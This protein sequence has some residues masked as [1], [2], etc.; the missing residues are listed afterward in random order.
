MTA[1]RTLLRSSALLAAATAAVLAAGCGDSSSDDNATAAEGATPAAEQISTPAAPDTGKIGVFPVPGTPTASPQTQ[2]SIRGVSAKD[3]GELTVTGA[4][5]G[6][7][8]GTVKAHSD[9][10]GASFLPDEPFSKTGE[11]VTVKSALAIAGVKGGEY[12][13]TVVGRPK[14]GLQSD[15]TAL[16]PKLLKALTGQSGKVVQGDATFKSRR[17]LRPPAIQILKKPAKTAPGEIFLSPKIVFGAKRPKVQNGPMILDDAGNPIW[18]AATG[19]SS[20][21]GNANR[22][23]DFRVQTYKGEPHLTWW[24]GRQVLG[25]GEGSVQIVDKN[26]KKVKTVEGGNGYKLDFHEARLTDQGTLLGL[27]YNPVD[28]DLTSVGGPKKGRVVDA[29][30]QEIDIETGLVLFEWHSIG[31]IPLEESYEDTIPKNGKSLFDYVHANSLALTNDG[32]LILSGREVWSGYKLNRE[33]GEL[34]AKIGGKDSDYKMLG[35]SQFAYQHDIE[36]LPDGTLSVYDNEAA[37]QVRDQ[38][39]GLLLDIDE[40]KKTVSV[41]AE[42]KH[43]PKKLTSGTQGS[44]QLL[45]NGN[46]F[47]EWGSQGYFSEFDAK[48]KMLYDGRIARGQD[49]YRGYRHEWVGTPSTKPD[50]VVVKSSAYGSWNGATEV[51]EWKLLTGTSKDAVEK[52][53]GS[54]KAKGFETRITIKGAEQFVAM[55]ALDKDGEVLGTSRV[56]TYKK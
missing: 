47:V 17:D 26:Y 48:G 7:H 28:M 1:P 21:A 29:V 30:A 53:I 55:Q 50:A 19:D 35:K 24:Q 25:T 38:S 14:A 42:L 32:N 16:D 2:I 27:V 49:S 18:F 37:P 45:P 20:R 22:V 56:R 51:A 36:Q 9:G 44:V 13:F 34:M 40:D 10:K 23:N 12:S 3:V 11:K 41:Q 54:A 43:Q 31:Q 15:P 8:A 39:R 46:H 5:S 52:E 33:T 4:K 6:A